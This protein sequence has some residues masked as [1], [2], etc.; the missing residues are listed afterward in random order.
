METPPKLTAEVSVVP[1]P[2]FT[3]TAMPL[4]AVFV[5]TPPKVSAPAPLS[6]MVRLAPMLTVP[7]PRFRLLAAVPTAV[8]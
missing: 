4:V 7:V 1:V 5:S 2:L 3:V 8:P 6:V